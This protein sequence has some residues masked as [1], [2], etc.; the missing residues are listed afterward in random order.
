MTASA[1]HET[2]QSETGQSGTRA[3]ELCLS[4]A[5]LETRVAMLETAILGHPMTDWGIPSND[6]K[7]IIA[8]TCVLFGVSIDELMSDRRTTRISQARFAASWALRRALGWSMTRIAR[9]LGKKDHSSVFHA[10][11]RAIELR[12]LNTKY[13]N[14]TD[15]LIA[16]HYERKVP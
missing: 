14:M 5:A 4:C 1:F 3:P 12:T 13:A 2:G 6:S 7:E 8:D 10:L 9:A 15:Q 11:G 16:Y